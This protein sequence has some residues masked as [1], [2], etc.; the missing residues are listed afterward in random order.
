MKRSIS[1]LERDRRFVIETVKS[2]T[3]VESLRVDGSRGENDLARLERAARDALHAA[4]IREASPSQAMAIAAFHARAEV[5]A[6]ARTQ[7]SV[8]GSLR[9]ASAELSRLED[10]AR[11]EVKYAVR[12]G[13]SLRAFL[14][15]VRAEAFGD[16]RAVLDGVQRDGFDG[17]RPKPAVR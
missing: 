12:E 15:R 9:D 17:E 16:V 6:E 10:I 14:M 13:D 4:A 11:H 5:L 7:V 8:S 3:G 1:E 2:L